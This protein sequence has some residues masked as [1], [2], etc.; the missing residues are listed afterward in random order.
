MFFQTMAAVAMWR[1][2][3]RAVYRWK[4]LSLL[5]LLSVSCRWGGPTLLHQKR[6]RAR[7][8]WRGL[9]GRGRAGGICTHRRVPNPRSGLP[10]PFAPVFCECLHV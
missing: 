8:S 3:T 9:S 5:S 1:G 10:W 4:Q 2:I 6:G 7:R